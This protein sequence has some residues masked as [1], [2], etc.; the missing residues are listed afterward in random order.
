MRN[1]WWAQK[2]GLS[3]VFLIKPKHFLKKELNIPQFF[4]AIFKKKNM[5]RCAHN[6]STEYGQLFP[7]KLGEEIKIWCEFPLISCVCLKWAWWFFLCT[8]WLFCKIFQ[9]IFKK[10]KRVRKLLLRS[11]IPCCFHGVFLYNNPHSKYAGFPHKHSSVMSIWRWD[12]FL[13]IN[14]LG[15][16]VLPVFPCLFPPV[17]WK[18]SRGGGHWDWGVGIGHIRTQCSSLFSRIKWHRSLAFEDSVAKSRT[19]SRRWDHV[20]VFYHF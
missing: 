3:G 13:W 1:S 10:D 7:I 16:R 5:S 11:P 18:P 17:S 6:T 14:D 19:K 9:R 8:K 20:L 4:F 15:V 12:F 2:E